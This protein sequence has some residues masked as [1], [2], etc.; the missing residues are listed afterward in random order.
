MANLRPELVIIDDQSPIIYYQIYDDSLCPIITNEKLNAVKEWFK[1]RNESF[2]NSKIPV[3]IIRTESD[4]SKHVTKWMAK[5]ILTPDSIEEYMNKRDVLINSAFRSK[6]L[7]SNYDRLIYGI[8]GDKK[9]IKIVMKHLL[10]KMS[11][12]RDLNKICCIKQ[13]D[14]HACIKLPSMI[15]TSRLNELVHFE[16][17]A[18]IITPWDTS[19]GLFYIL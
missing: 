9:E 13:S 7:L 10:C 2:K 1:N 12:N 15:S 11:S 19:N 16:P 6:R 17:I 4:E 8:T 5:D 3:Q 14:L 18:R